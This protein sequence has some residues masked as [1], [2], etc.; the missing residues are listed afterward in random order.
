[1]H[2][3]VYPLSYFSWITSFPVFSPLPLVSCFPT[4]LPALVRASVPSP[5]LSHL[6]RPSLSSFHPKPQAPNQ[7]SKFSQLPGFQLL[8]Q[9]S[10]TCS[11]PFPHPSNYWYF[12]PVPS[13]WVSTL[14]LSTKRLLVFQ[15]GVP[16]QLWDTNDIQVGSHCMLT[17]HLAA[18]WERAPT[19]Q[20]W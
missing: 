17:D 1:M 9:V 14:W 20:C 6:I 19:L 8:S 2:Q 3:S 16:E 18:C 5:V 13:L 10:Q 4:V 11:I 7:G 12:I 15:P